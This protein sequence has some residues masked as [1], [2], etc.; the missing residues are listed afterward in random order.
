M[1]GYIKINFSDIHIKINHPK[2]LNVIQELTFK[3]EFF[4]N[5]TSPFKDREPNYAAV[6]E[7]R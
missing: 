1:L 6:V 7:T 3:L 5:F 4:I 2:I